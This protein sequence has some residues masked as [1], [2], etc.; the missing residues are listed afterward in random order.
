MTSSKNHTISKIAAKAVLRIV[1]I[2]I[3]LPVILYF[4][5][6]KSMA[7]Q[8][9]FTNVWSIVAPILLLLSFLVL[10]ITVLREKYAKLEWNWLLALSG[11][12]LCLYLIMFSIKV[13]S[14]FN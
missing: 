8:V 2:L 11:I 3:A 5:H 10:L 12:F 4:T 9:S 1:V 6:P 14:I 13:L 7:S